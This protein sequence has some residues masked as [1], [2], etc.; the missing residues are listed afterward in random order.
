MDRIVFL[1][2][3]AVAGSGRGDAFRDQVH[4]RPLRRHHGG[5]GPQRRG[6][7]RGTRLP[8]EL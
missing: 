6:A 1:V 5:R 2:E 7:L 3:T 4:Q 8:S